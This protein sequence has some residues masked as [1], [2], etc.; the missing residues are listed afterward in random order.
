[1]VRVVVVGGLFYR[2]L[3]SAL[4]VGPAHPRLASRGSGHGRIAYQSEIDTLPGSRELPPER[5]LEA[6]CH[7]ACADNCGQQQPDPGQILHR[8]RAAIPGHVS[9]ISPRR[10]QGARVDKPASQQVPPLD[11]SLARSAREERARHTRAL[12]DRS[13]SHSSDGSGSSCLVRMRPAACLQVSRPA[14]SVRP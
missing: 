12:F 2:P 5:Y 6:S 1:M 11:Y 4:P 10:R 14:C 13:F 9:I 8:I 3:R 7:A